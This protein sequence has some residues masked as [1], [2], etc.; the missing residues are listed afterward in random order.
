LLTSQI[1]AGVKS[2]L[3]LPGINYPDKYMYELS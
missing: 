2:R 3:F 1:K